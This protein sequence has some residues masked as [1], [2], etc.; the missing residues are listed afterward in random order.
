MTSPETGFS[1]RYCV[2]RELGRGGV[3]TVYLALDLKFQRLVA[4]KV[5]RPELAASL[6]HERFLREIKIGPRLN[7]PHILQLH[8]SGEAGGRLFYAMPYVDGESLRQRLEREGQL[9]IA[10]TIAIVQAVASALTH[11]HQHGVIHRDIKPE[12]ILLARDSDGGPAHPLVA[13]FVIA[14][15]LDAAGGA[16][17]TETGLGLGTPAYMSPEHAASG[18]LDGRS[19]IYALGCVAYEMLAGAPPFTGPTAQAVRARHAADPVP[20]LHTVRVTTP[21]AVEAAIERALA[22]V[23]ADRFPTADEF[24]QAMVAQSVARKPARRTF[25]LGRRALAPG[26]LAATVIGV[27]GLLVRGASSSALLPSASRIAVLPFLSLGADTALARLGKDLANTISTTLAGVGGIAVADRLSIGASAAGRE[28]SPTDG[29]ALA[30]RL[31]ATSVVRG[32]LVGAGDQVRLDLGLYDTEGLQPLARG[33]TLTAHRDSVRSLTDSASLGLLR[34]IWQR[35]EPPSPSLGAA[36]TP[37]IPALRAFLDGERAM[38]EDRWVDA[39]LAYAA[40]INADSTFAL[41]YWRQT[42]AKWWRN[43]RPDSASLAIAMA[44]ITQLPEKERLLAEVW[45][46]NLTEPLREKL[47]FRAR[48]LTERFPNFWPGWF[49]YGDLL[50]HAGPLLG[51]DLREAREALERTVQ[52]NPQLM[53]AWDHLHVTAIVLEDTTLLARTLTRVE[54]HVSQ[55]TAAPGLYRL[56][57]MLLHLKKGGHFEG[58]LV[59]TLVAYHVRVP[60]IQ[61]QAWSATLLSGTGHPAAQLEFSQR[62]LAAGPGEVVAAIHQKAVASAWAAAGSWDSALAATDAYAAQAGKLSRLSQEQ[63]EMIRASPDLANFEPY[64]IAAVGAWLGALDPA[65]AQV[66]RGEAARAA[67]RMASPFRH[68]ELFWLDGILA[69]SK[70]ELA[71]LRVAQ[72]ELRKARQQLA[73]NDTKS[74]RTLIRSLA[75]FELELLGRRRQAAD[76]MAAV[77]WEWGEWVG[78]YSFGI[79]RMAAARWLVAEHQL[80]QAARL[81]PWHQ[82]ALLDIPF[83][84]AKVTLEGLAYL[85]MARVEAAR[86]NRSQAREYYERFLQRYDR[87]SPKMRHLVDEAKAALARLEADR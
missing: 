75:A 6:G 11:A 40:A 58:P 4:L 62:I 3:A 82:A 64:R 37:S 31:G 44:Y 53:P 57:P 79:S 67:V 72:S 74:Y 35:G 29:A 24:A 33:V 39:E 78:P 45:N 66:R 14:R 26:F 52:L 34:Q 71:G 36:T 13:D 41:A 48:D 16:R 77:S 76:S 32:T 15:V 73:E 85:E 19:D 8:D 54:A 38:V 49:E 20:P 22:K 63:I 9:P 30:R 84:H 17:P 61:N 70:R 65:L 10:D 80:D 69:A 42:Y 87:P 46:E 83:D 68:M 56:A 28:L 59:D 21:P 51:H 18:R 7:H 2:E 55:G 86:S 25:K 50:F 27:G 12:N 5:L 1:E 23:P 47:L 60:D 81:L 43:E